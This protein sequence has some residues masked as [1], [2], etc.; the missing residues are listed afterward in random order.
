VGKLFDAI[1]GFSE[2]GVDDYLG[3]SV[4]VLHFV[5]NGFG[6]NETNGLQDDSHIG[7]HLYL[8]AF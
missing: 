2:L 7:R 8:S 5:T 6:F 4:F 3:D 1:Q